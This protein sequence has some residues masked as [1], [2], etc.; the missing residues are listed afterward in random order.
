M[1]ETAQLLASK[2]DNFTKSKDRY[3]EE[4]SFCGD[5]LNDSQC[6]NLVLDD[7]SMVSHENPMIS[8]IPTPLDVAK[9][10]K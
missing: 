7:M 8:P 9:M 4:V 10:H 5:S 1:V 2:L 3:A 6:E